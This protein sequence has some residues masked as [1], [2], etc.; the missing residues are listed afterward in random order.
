M[1]TALEF[2]VL[3][4]LEVWRSGEPVKLGAAK[5]RALLGLLLI[6]RSAVDRDVAVD[7]LWGQRPPKDAR[8][9]L[10]VYVSALRR[11][12][13]RELI[14]T[15]SQGYRLK[16][17]PGAMDADRFEELYRSGVEVLVEGDAAQAR[18]LLV[19][20]LALWR[21]EAFADLRFDAFAQAEAGRLDELRLA[22][23]EERVEADLRLGRHAALVGELEAFAIE[24]PL[25]ERLRGQLILALYRSGRQAESLAQYQATRRMLADELGL[26]PSPQLKELERMILAHDPGLNAPA[27]PPRSR[28][29]LPLQPTPFVGRE[30]ELEELVGLISSGV[31]RLVTLTGPGGTGK[32]RLAIEAA[33]RLAREYEEGV[34]W[35]PLQSI[36]EAGLVFPTIAGVLG[37][38][39]ELVEEIGDRNML[40][41]L[42]NFEQ[43]HEAGPETAALLERCPNL[44]LLITSRERLHVAAEREC[45][46]LPMSESDAVVL[47]DERAAGKGGKEL[48]AEICLRLDC[49]PLAIELAAAQT[50]SLEPEQILERLDV[51]LAFL[52]DGPRDAPSRQ[53]TL[54]ATL[55]WSYNLL[56]PEEQTLFAQLGVFAEGGY[57]G[58][59][60]TVCGLSSA[61][62]DSLANKSLVR[63]EAGSSG[64]PRYVLLQTIR[65]YAIERLHAGGEGAAVQRRH[66]E[67]FAGLAER[68]RRK[69]FDGISS[70]DGADERIVDELPNL[71]AALAFALEQD[72]LQLALRLAGA[73]SLVWTLTGAL[74]EGRAVLTEV[75]DRTEHL[76]TPERSELLIGLGDLETTLGDLPAAE[77]FYQQAEAQ[78]KENGDAL[79]ALHAVL[80]SVSL[81]PMR[82]D[83]EESRRIIEAAYVMAAANGNSYHRARILFAE[84]DLDNECGDWEQADAR[85]AEGLDLVRELNLSPE[86]WG[87][88]LVN[89]GWFAMQRDDYPRAR[90]AL[91]EYL[92]G[93]AG[94]RSPGVAA[95]RGTLGLVALCEENR[96]DAADQFRLA[97][98]LSVDLRLRPQIAE[99]LRGMAAVAAIDGDPERSARLVGAA[100][101]IAEQT[102]MVLT[103]P[104]QL[105]ADTYLEP[106]RAALPAD[107]YSRAWAEGAAMTP[108]EAV[109]YAL[110]CRP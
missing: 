48:V 43:V 40:L 17:E 38:G 19:E 5:Q 97:L 13:G 84:A 76:Q 2:R 64:A 80:C 85:L 8:N 59:V 68:E 34:Y 28:S 1:D 96:D 51:R 25:R 91:E 37:A 82:R 87:W 46:V 14:E 83:R 61:R 33:R 52:T 70:P 63:C 72:D 81:T 71:R 77:R 107:T 4:P 7:A 12:L 18:D 57:L 36:M 105:I 102:S 21:G 86:V 53:Q 35:V 50:R 110:G 93:A 47:F 62:L 24:Q 32:T 10:Q 95:A 109:A 74:M 11:A 103:G 30:R 65:D 55:E 16:V 106:S 56:S 45:P 90:A 54:G 98:H 58:A 100:D 22:C 23:V 94:R 88:Q 78:S 79:G 39:R 26:E 99:S 67:Y 73:G 75:L 101:A 89:L 66:A 69:R 44:V 108:D 49:L 20:A 41:L 9:T 31:R 104:E 15:T 29:N 6:R 27:L 92:E 3:G 42:D 60:E